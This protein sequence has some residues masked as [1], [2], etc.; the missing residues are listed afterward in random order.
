M[1][2]QR[3][4]NFKIRMTFQGLDNQTV[5]IRISNYQFPNSMEDD[6]DDNWLNIYLNV[7]SKAGNWQVIDP[8]LTTAEFKEL[9]DWFR[10][11][12]QNKK[13]EY[14]RLTFIE[15]NLSFELLNSFDNISKE[16]K[17][18]FNLESRPQSATNDK[19]YFVDCLADNNML[20]KIADELKQ[21][22]DNYPE[23]KPAQ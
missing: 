23:R 4:A 17:I 8:S 2:T 6:W 10:N 11:L 3:L 22:L 16:F 13:P 21:E 5:E 14:A 9:I 1:K 15:P 19:D 7:K 18:K 20:L 12:S